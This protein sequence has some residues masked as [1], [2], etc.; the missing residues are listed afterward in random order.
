M[1]NKEQIDEKL[2]NLGKAIGSEEKLVENVMSRIEKK[3]TINML[4]Q[5]PQNI[6]S[7]VMKNP[8]RKLAVA[9][10]IIA[11]IVGLSIFQFNNQAYGIA[12]VS[13]IIR[14][15]E[16]I[17][18]K[19]FSTIGQGN[20]VVVE[21]NS[22]RE[23]EYLEDW[24]DI[25]NGKFHTMGLG[26]IGMRGIS[27]VTTI[28][29]EHIFDGEYVMEKNRSSRQVRF[30]RKS[31]FQR[32]L[33][34]RQAVDHFLDEISLSADQL[35]GFTKSETE[36]FDGDNYEIWEKI[37]S[38]YE[39]S[40]NKLK[41]W[42]SP[43]SGK[44]RKYQQWIKNSETNGKW[45]LSYEKIIYINQ[46]PPE[47]IFSTEV[48]EGYQASNTKETASL[49]ELFQTHILL[50]DMKGK[51][52]VLMALRNGTVIMAWNT[53]DV[54]MVELLENLNPGDKISEIPLKL[55]YDLRDKDNPD[56]ITYEVRHLTLTQKDYVSY[57]WYIYVPSKDLFGTYLS[58]KY[59]MYQGL[60]TTD[61]NENDWSKVYFREGQINWIGPFSS[62][63][64]L[65]IQDKEEFN[66][67]VL[68]A[69]S[70]LSDD[71]KVPEDITYEKVLSLS[72]QIRESIP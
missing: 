51:V 58:R 32:K 40:E 1:N 2:E 23:K 14:K 34:V 63:V 59:Q 45:Q 38:V 3:Q 68:G 20:P 60:H 21:E 7:K 66:T 15:A 64:Q 53:N 52:N 35:T 22:I 39:N 30:S 37:Q 5:K 47:D 29:I 62:E 33:S 26:L 24:I 65:I 48:P 10:I 11:V 13:T 71:G 55:K 46:T 28:T 57:E 27:S 41:Y 16:T 67:F 4:Q 6:W 36:Q 69:M 12:D 19:T 49:E 9:T 8:V 31:D 50:G 18:I 54:S 17:H 42:V 72:Q 25:K 61:Y 43:S 44:I 56:K 70:E